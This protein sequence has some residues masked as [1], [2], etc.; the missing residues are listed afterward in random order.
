MGCCN[1]KRARWGRF[2]VPVR[3]TTTASGRAATPASREVPMTRSVAFEY[4]GPTAMSVMG[5]ITRTQY[6][7]H[8]T[9][10]RLGIDHRDVP[11][12]TGVPNL[13]RVPGDV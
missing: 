9:G 4:V 7:F 8:N 10:A 3:S 6:R 11:Y 1:E 2:A 13:R 5:P 12:V